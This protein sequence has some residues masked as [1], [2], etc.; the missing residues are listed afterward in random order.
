M[1]MFCNPGNIHRWLFTWI[2][3]KSLNG[4]FMK[5]QKL[6]TKDPFNELLEI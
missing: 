2:E 5:L 3:V 1:A 4:P 6:F